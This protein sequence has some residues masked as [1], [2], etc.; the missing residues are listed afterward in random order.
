M[1]VSSRACIVS[2]FLHLDLKSILL[3]MFFKYFISWLIFC[4]LVS[5]YNYGFIY[6]FLSR[7]FLL[8]VFWSSELGAYSIKDC[9]LYVE[10][11]LLLLWKILLFLGIY[12]SWSLLC[13]MLIQSFS[14]LMSNICKLFLLT[15]MCF[16]I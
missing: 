9:C 6:F 8:H 10:L 1:L 13:L 3:I 14:I 7:L 12:L 4:L 11:T 15:Y 5:S 16:N 2:C